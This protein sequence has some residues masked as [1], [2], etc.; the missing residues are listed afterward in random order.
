[1]LFYKAGQHNVINITKLEIIYF[2]KLIITLIMSTLLNSASAKTLK[3]LPL[4]PNSPNCVSSQMPRKDKEHYIA[5]FKMTKSVERV[6]LKL[7]N[8]LTVQARTQ[9]IEDKEGFLKAQTHSL[10]FKFI[11]DLY[12]IFDEKENKVHIYSASRTGY[13]DFGVNRRRLEKIRQQLQQALM[14]D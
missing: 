11:D 6:Q 10:I 12:F 1:M 14:I 2:L 3:K 7:K 13:S 4:C 8:L 5:A 9:I